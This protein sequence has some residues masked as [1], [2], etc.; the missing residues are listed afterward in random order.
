MADP[1][2]VFD[3][4]NRLWQLDVGGKYYCKGPGEIPKSCS[5]TELAIKHG[6]VN[7]IVKGDSVKIPELIPDGTWVSFNLK[8][9]GDLAWGQVEAYDPD[10]V[11]YDI[12][13]KVGRDK[14]R[15]VD[16]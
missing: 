9:L 13:I 1:G 5:L 7:H 6:P 14:V 3:G 12:I 4:K 2:F 10:N 15:K 11:C 16:Q 8:E